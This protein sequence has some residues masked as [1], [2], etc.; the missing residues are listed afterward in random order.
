MR[1]ERRRGRREWVVKVKVKVKKE[2][3]AVKRISFPLNVSSPTHR[4]FDSLPPCMHVA[5]IGK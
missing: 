2:W 5:G 3:T 4:S 1:G